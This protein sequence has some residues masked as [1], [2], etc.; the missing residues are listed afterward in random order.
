M[1]QVEFIS[2]NLTGQEKRTE[3][4]VD[5]VTSG[6]RDLILS[7][8]LQPGTRIGQDAL[9]KRFGTSRLP[10]RDALR[11]IES[12][13][14]V[15]L[16]PNTSARVA[17]LELRECEEIYMIRE[18]IEPLALSQSIPNM[19]DEQIQA[20]EKAV[21]EIESTRD[22]DIFLKLDR[23]FHLSSYRA[24]NMPQLVGLV[25][26]FWNT[27]QHY[28]RA[29]TKLVWNQGSWIINSEHRLLMDAIKRRDPID[30]GQILR[31]HIRRTRK[32]LSRHEE[33]FDVPSSRRRS[34]NS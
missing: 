16:T 3:L 10:V 21:S 18:L 25:G 29:Y 7:G 27:T 2:G 23:E 14:L 9:A 28:R 19:S 5:R 31:M 22:S 13:G 1:S 17:K 4:L 34:G 32:E 8:D 20:L 26:R 12:E 24:A 30:A 6:I 33:L 15:I 11:Q